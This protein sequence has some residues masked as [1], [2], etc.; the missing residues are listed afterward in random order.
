MTSPLPVRRASL[1]SAAPCPHYHGLGPALGYRR[2]GDA[3]RRIG[4]RGNTRSS[5]WMSASCWRARAGPRR[6]SHGGSADRGPGRRS[7]RRRRADRSG[8]ARSMASH[9]ASRGS[10]PAP[11]RRWPV[12][13]VPTRRPNAESTSKWARQRP[14]CG[15]ERFSPRSHG[16]D[17]RLTQS[18]SQ[19]TSHSLRFSHCSEEVL[20]RG[21]EPGQNQ[22]S[23]SFLRTWQCSPSGRLKQCLPE[24]DRFL[25]GIRRPFAG[26]G[27]GP[28]NHRQKESPAKGLSF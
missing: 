16:F 13:P 4:D 12:V 5:S 8:N 18:Q 28:A 19:V 3:Y 25:M 1:D 7:A 27:S 21:G 22:V 14:G 11:L 2:R 10:M 9:G 26:G 23:Y 20:S 15:L 6:R 24:V 17:W